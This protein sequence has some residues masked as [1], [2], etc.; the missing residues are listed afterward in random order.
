MSSSFALSLPL[1]RLI[2]DAL[3]TFDHLPF[4]LRARSSMAYP[5]P[6]F[7]NLL[8]TAKRSAYNVSA[9][10]ALRGDRK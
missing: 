7:S 5:L 6:E 3:A 9:D 1:P 10:R 8:P 4:H 2:V